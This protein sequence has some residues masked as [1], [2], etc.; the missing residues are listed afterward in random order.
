MSQK[1]VLGMASAQPLS[2]GYAA[3]AA[4]VVDTRQQHPLPITVKQ[5]PGRAIAVNVNMAASAAFPAA[6]PIA[7]GKRPRDG[8]R[9]TSPHRAPVELQC[10]GTLILYVLRAQSVCFRERRRVRVMKHCTMRT[11]DSALQHIVRAECVAPAC[12]LHSL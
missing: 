12:F 10:Q 2:G 8:S 6:S 11:H 9:A 7:C 3:A 4:R 1:F 5:E